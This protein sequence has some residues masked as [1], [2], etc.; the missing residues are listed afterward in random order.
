MA[1]LILAMFLGVVADLWV[2]HHRG[3][4]SPNDGLDG[5]FTGGRGVI[6]I[7]ALPPLAARDRHGR[8]A[9]GLPH[10]S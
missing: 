3:L 9:C 4:A 1:M 8:V 5:E 10:S 6:T 2:T 7:L